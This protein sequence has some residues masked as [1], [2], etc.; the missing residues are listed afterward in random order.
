[1]L[2]E[3]DLPTQRPVTPERYIVCFC[4]W[5]TLGF[6]HNLPWFMAMLSTVYSS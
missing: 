4:Y 1:M 6:R 3:R 2:S 5:F